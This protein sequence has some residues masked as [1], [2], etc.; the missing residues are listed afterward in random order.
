M[1]AITTAKRLFNQPIRYSPA[2]GHAEPSGFGERAD[3]V[4]SRA[5]NRDSVCRNR[6]AGATRNRDHCY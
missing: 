2:T 5:P 6:A 1:A 3:V 4:G